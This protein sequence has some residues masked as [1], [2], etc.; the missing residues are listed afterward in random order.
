M[1]RKNEN[2]EKEAVSG[3]VFFKKFITYTCSR[4]AGRPRALEQQFLT[5]HPY[6]L[7]FAFKL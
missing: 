6:L 1:Y 3:P 5:L 7:S 4:Y 2:E